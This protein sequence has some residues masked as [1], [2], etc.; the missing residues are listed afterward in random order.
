M[1]RAALDKELPVEGDSASLLSTGEATPA[2]L[3]SDLGFSTGE[4]HGG[5]G[6][7][8]QRATKMINDLEHLFCEKRLREWSLFILERRRLSSMVTN[9]QGMV[10]RRL[11]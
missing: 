8:L 4:R 7:S 6:G 9:T 3:C 2:V 1:S 5:T 11:R 10:Y